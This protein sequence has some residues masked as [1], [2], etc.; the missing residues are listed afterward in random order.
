MSIYLRGQVFHYDFICKGKRYQGSTAKTNRAEAKAV[1]D[2]V[3]SK[4]KRPT[5]AYRR[6]TFQKTGKFGRT[7]KVGGPVNYFTYHYRVRKVRGRPNFCE[8]CWS[9][10]PS[11]R[12]EWA[13]ITGNL[14]DVNDYLRLCKHCHAKY[15]AQRRAQANYLT[16]DWLLNFSGAST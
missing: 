5:L 4:L 7:W 15:D 13:N 1:E 9:T 14:G 2:E 8:H 10:D 16:S 12:Y 11:K 3:R 6:G